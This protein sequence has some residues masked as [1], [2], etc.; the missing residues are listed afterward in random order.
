MIGNIRGPGSLSPRKPQPQ[1]AQH[2][3]GHKPDTL[4]RIKFWEMGLLPLAF[5]V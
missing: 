2:F 1:R 5:G 3:T 4:P